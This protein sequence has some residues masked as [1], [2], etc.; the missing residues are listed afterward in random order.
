M[1]VLTV[2]VHVSFLTRTRQVMTAPRRPDPPVIIRCNQRSIVVKWYPGAGGACKYRLQSRL[3]E[4]L[5][6]VGALADATR[7]VG[8]SGGGLAGLGNGR[9]R[10]AWGEGGDGDTA[11]GWVTVYEGVDSTA[12]VMRNNDGL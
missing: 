4:G 2:G 1:Y 5:D 8:G 9:R 12:K 11:T 6:G 3:V 10:K 7:L